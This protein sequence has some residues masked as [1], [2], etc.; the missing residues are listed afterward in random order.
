M[1]L[2]A[3]CKLLNMEYIIFVLMHLSDSEWGPWRDH[4]CDRAL[5]LLELPA[6]ENIREECENYFGCDPD[7]ISEASDRCPTRSSEE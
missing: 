4:W 1:V 6:N 3:S 7:L 5:D 2:A